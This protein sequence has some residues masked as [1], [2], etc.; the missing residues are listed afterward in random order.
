MAARRLPATG[1]GQLTDD[2]LVRAEAAW[3]AGDAD[4]AFTLLNDVYARTQDARY[5]IRLAGLVQDCGLPDKA[6]GILAAIIV[7]NPAHAFAQAEYARILREKRLAADPAHATDVAAFKATAAAA[8]AALEA[9]PLFMPSQFWRSIGEKHERMLFGQG[10]GNFKRTV[11]HNYQNWLLTDPADAQVARLARIWAE[12]RWPQVLLNTLELPDNAGF[13]WDRQVP[14]YPL[15]DP[16][17]RA[18]YA[19]SV[20]TLWEHVLENDRFGFLRDTAEETIGNPIALRREGRLISQDHAHSARELTLLFGH[21]GLDRKDALTVLEL[22]AGQG[23]L[24]EMLGKTTGFRHFVVDIPPTIC[25]SQWYVTKLFGADAVFAYRRFDDWREIEAELAGKRFAFFT[26]DQTR[27]FPAKS[28]DVT[29]NICS[30]MEMTPAQIAYFLARIPE[31]TRKAFYS[32]QWKNWRN[33]VDG[34]AVVKTDFA[35]PGWRATYDADDDVHPELFAQI[36]EP[37]TAA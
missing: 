33:P 17:A 14:V 22:G 24:A 19:F 28:V 12:R 5:G 26:P 1:L 8:W 15:T 9:A 11:G 2:V 7:R 20:G 3:Q 23:R 34:N 29:I 10:L 6:L 36:W 25:V 37:E 31:V 32:R 13:I 21:L 16:A 35:V 18:A 4:T 30:L 27:H